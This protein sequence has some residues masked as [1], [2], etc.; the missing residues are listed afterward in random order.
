MKVCI[1]CGMPMQELSDY[2]NNDTSKNYCIHCARP[3][4]TMMSLDEKREA[5]TSFIVRTQGFD[6]KA[7]R[8]VAESN[9][10]KFPA[11]EKYYE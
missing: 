6:E 5:M 7:A 11:W 1:S 3:D 8:G 10:R 2:P 9:M 4:G